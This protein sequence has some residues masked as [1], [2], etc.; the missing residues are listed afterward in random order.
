[1]RMNMPEFDSIQE[2]EQARSDR[3]WDGMA[4]WS[5]SRWPGA[6]YMLGYAAEIALKCACFRFAGIPIMQPIGSA[7]LRTAYMQARHLGVTTPN[8]SGHSVRFWRDWLVEHRRAV[9]RPL[10]PALED[11]LNSAVDAI[12]DRWWIEMRY[13]QARSSPVDL[14]ILAAAVDW[15]ER[16]YVTLHT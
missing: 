2:Y 5:T 12:Y 8:E 11:S 15:I 9:G 16:N 6:V 4:L 10:S 13:K 3:L 7:E 14:E 1:M